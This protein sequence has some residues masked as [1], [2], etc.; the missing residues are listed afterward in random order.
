MDNGFAFYKETEDGAEFV[1]N[2]TENE[3]RKLYN[4]ATETLGAGE[5]A[6]Y[7]QMDQAI[8]SYKVLKNKYRA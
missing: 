8:L 3:A 1:E 6:G 2:I 5:L 7:A 4:E